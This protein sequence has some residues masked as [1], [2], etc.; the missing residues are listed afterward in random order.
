MGA[1]SRSSLGWYRQLLLWTQANLRKAYGRMIIL[2]SEP[3]RNTAESLE[4]LPLVSVCCT[5][6]MCTLKLISLQ[7][8]VSWETSHSSDAPFS[9][10]SAVHFAE[11]C[12]D[13]DGKALSIV[14]QHCGDAKSTLANRHRSLGVFTLYLHKQ[15]VQQRVQALSLIF[16][17]SLSK[18]PSLAHFTP[19]SGRRVLIKVHASLLQ[20]SQVPNVL[21]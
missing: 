21:E 8:R 11:L 7:S 15:I 4:T 3:R 12:L 17:S 20:S 13:D 14:E 5:F 6:F 1:F 10:Q 9:Q 18:Y 19:W 16:R 2:M